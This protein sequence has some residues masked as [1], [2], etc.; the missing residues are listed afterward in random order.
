MSKLICQLCN[1]VVALFSVEDIKLP[2]TG[3]MFHSPDE[4]H[5]IPDPFYPGAEFEFMRCPYGGHR[6]MILPDQLLTDEGMLNIPAEG[7]PYFTPAIP[8]NERSF[9]LDRGDNILPVPMMSDEEAGRRAR[10]LPV[11]VD[12]LGLVP[13][14]TQ[15][16]IEGDTLLIIDEKNFIER[17]EGDGKTEIQQW[18]QA[19][20]QPVKAKKETAS[21]KCHLCGQPCKSKSA[22]KNH[23]RTKHRIINAEVPNNAG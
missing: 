4:R 9:I 11:T 6:P 14:G 23:M 13:R 1:E 5:G 20:D 21:Y 17:T 3:S 16:H 18:Q 12:E 15:A 7:K 8:N 22:Y 10:G 19:D 2:I